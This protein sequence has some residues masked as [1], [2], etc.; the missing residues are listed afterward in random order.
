[1]GTLPPAH[2]ELGSAVLRQLKLIEI[3]RGQ[4]R[5]P[6]LRLVG[7]RV[8][9]LLVIVGA[10]LVWSQADLSILMSWPSVAGFGL[11]VAGL[12]V[13]RDRSKERIEALVEFL[14]AEG[15]LVPGGRR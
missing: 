12:A 13:P 7:E 9:L 14:E 2:A 8:R 6:L 10:L 15:H 1:M 5:P 3:A 4:S 11:L